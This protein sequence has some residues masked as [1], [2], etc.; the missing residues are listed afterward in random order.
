MGRLADTLDNHGRTV[1]SAGV[2]V[3]CSEVVAASCDWVELGRIPEVEVHA[4]M[5]L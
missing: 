1:K 3:S 5:G 2:V 4:G